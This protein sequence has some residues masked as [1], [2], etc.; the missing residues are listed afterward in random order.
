M[1]KNEIIHRYYKR[2]D[3]RWFERQNIVLKVSSAVAEI[4][5]FCLEVD[6]K[7]EVIHSKDVVAKATY[8]ITLLEKANQQI[9]F[10]RKERLKNALSKDYKT[11]CEQDHSHSKEMLGDDLAGNGKKTKAAHSINQSISN[12]RL[13]LSSSCPRDPTFLYS[14]NSKTSTSATHFLNIQGSKKNFQHP[15]PTTRWNQK[16]QLQMKWN[17]M[18]STTWKLKLI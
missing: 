11:I 16:Q 8:A 15:Q 10:E 2:N 4:A 18:L 3:N 7:N 9:T 17:K 5:S 6:N 14:S 13:R 1:I 12:K